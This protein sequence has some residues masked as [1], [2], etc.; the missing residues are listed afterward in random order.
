MAPLT[1]GIAAGDIIRGMTRQ[2]GN[3]I[4][5]FVT[6][7]L[8]NNLL[9]LPL[10]LATINLARGRDTGVPSLN[11]ARRSFYEAT[12]HNEQLKPYESWVDFAAN[13]KNETSIIN[14]IA[15]YGTHALITGQTTLEGKRDA[16]LTIIT[17]ISVG[18]LA[19]PADARTSSTVPAPM[20]RPTGLAAS[21]TSI[22][23]SAALPKRHAIRRHAGLDLQ[24]RVRDADG[25]SAERRPL[26]LPAAAR[27]PASLR[28]DGSN[29][30]A[31]MIMRNTNATHLPSDVF[32]TPGL[33]LEVDPDQAIQRP[34]RGR[35]PG[36]RPIRSAAGLLT[37][38]VIRNNPAHRGTG[39]Q[40]S[41]LHRRGARGS[42]RHR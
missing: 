21:T 24:V 15:A 8:R 17:G 14:F 2:L 41:A 25:E 32:S 38:L 27:R 12:N 40:L 11:D 37:Q 36:E 6:S 33:I 4:D 35:H 13:L 23:G 29:S 7:A 34:G 31:S 16:A 20:A 26:L 42:R 10:D 3:E 39:H 19:V 9:G 18:G 30:F 28:R 1:D 22:S 5:E